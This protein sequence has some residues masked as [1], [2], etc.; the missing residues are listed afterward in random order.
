MPRRLTRA[1]PHIERH[2]INATDA[3]VLHATLGLA[4]FLRV[5]GDDLA[6]VASDQRLLRAAKAE[7]LDT[8]DPETQDQATLSK[9]IGP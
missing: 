2:S 6:I 9:L 1:A 3:I 4:Q 8:F 5:N 7:G